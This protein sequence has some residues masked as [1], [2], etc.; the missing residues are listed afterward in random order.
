MLVFV[1][2]LFLLMLK[3][4]VGGMDLFEVGDIFKMLSYVDEVG[5]GDGV[6]FGKDSKVVYG[7]GE[8]FGGE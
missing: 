6:G 8:G 7:F 2:M 4:F 3:L 1:I 5:G